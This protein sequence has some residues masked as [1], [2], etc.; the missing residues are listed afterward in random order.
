MRILVPPQAM[1]LLQ[2]CRS[3]DNRSIYLFPILEGGNKDDGA[4]YRSYLRALRNFNKALTALLAL[5]LPAGVKFSSYT[6][7]HTWAPLAYLQ[8]TLV[9]AICKALGHSSIRVTENYLKPFDDEE[10]DKVNAE[11]ITNVTRGWK[12]SFAFNGM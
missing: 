10:V 5:L 3:K 11:V 6:A 7:R 9:G 12:T 1:A 2:T 8:G 4:V